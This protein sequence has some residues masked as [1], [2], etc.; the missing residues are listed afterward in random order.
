ME[1][2]KSSRPVPFYFAVQ[3]TC[4]PGPTRFSPPFRHWL[5]RES[6]TDQETLTV[7]VDVA[8]TGCRAGKTAVQLYVRDVESSVR[9]PVRY[10]E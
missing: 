1:A 5:D 7:S 9:R 4:L 10:T 8:N 2:E 6:L 3:K